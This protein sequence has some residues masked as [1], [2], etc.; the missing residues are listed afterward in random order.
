MSR[1][2]VITGGSS[3]IGL[4]CA[5]KFAAQGF[6]VY[7]LSRR[8]GD[9]AAI[10]HIACDVTDEAAV[11]AAFDRIAVQERGIDIVICNAGFGISG[12]AEFTA[13]EDAQAQF[14]V[15]FF[16][17]LRTAKAA[18][19]HLRNSRGRLIFMSSAAAVFPI[20]FQSFYAASKAAVNS[21]SSALR[22]ELKP[23]GVSVLALMP[24]DVHTGFTD[25][26]RHGEQGGELYGQRM[27]RAV[28]AMEK[29]EQNGMTSEYIAKKVYLYALKKHVAP[30]YTLGVKYK[31]LAALNKLLPFSAVNFLIGKI[32]G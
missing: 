26:R 28:A 1:T 17:A 23:F 29:D 21:L 6:T 8:G 3:G 16:G 12:A 4:A 22:N 14:D 7:E 18:I 31:L 10:R 19:P 5:K 25:A 24:G 27:H 32:Y 11:I 2:V 30:A 15:N 9:D 20:P 13:L